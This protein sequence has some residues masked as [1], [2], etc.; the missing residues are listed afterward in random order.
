MSPAAR[1]LA[2]GAVA[3]VGGSVATV[4][5]AG[6][7][8]SAHS[9]APARCTNPQTLHV[10][11]S[12]V[13]A[14]AV[15]TIGSSWPGND[16]AAR[17]RCARVSVSAM[18]DAQAEAALAGG[19]DRTTTL[20]IPDSS[21]WAQRLDADLRS[22]GSA[23]PGV[24]IGASVASSPMVYVVPSGA[25][26]AG[27][28]QV[29]PSTLS[30]ASFAIPDPTSSAEGVLAL[31]FLGLS[32]R[33]V[34]QQVGAMVRLADQTIAGPDAGFAGLLRG[35]PFLASEQDVILHNRA[36]G[37]AYASAVYPAQQLPAL[38]FP[39]VQL[40]RP[41]ERAQLAA[42]S[43]AFADVLSSRT[44]QGILAGLG[45][46]DAAGRPLARDGI[47]HPVA[48]LRPPTSGDTANLL[49]LWS[50]ATEASHTLVVID[51]SG[52]MAENAG[53]GQSKIQLAAAAATAAEAY[54]PNSSSFGLWAFSSDQSN[55]LPW[56]KLA[57]VRQ[58]GTEDQRQRLA[59]AGTKLPRLVGGDTALYDTALAAFQEIRNTYQP[60][61]VNSVVLL[62]D[63]KN[64]YP[65][66][67]TLP[68]LLT[69]LRSLV[70][71]ARPVPVITI[72]IGNQ[73]DLATLRQISAMTGGKAYAV[74][75]PTQVR[76]VFLDA[77]LQRECRPSC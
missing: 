45:L 13:I 38:D 59:A 64:V 24:R 40:T 12:P 14:A 26:P 60:G 25:K 77:M 55:G 34:A 23:S 70:D 73:A 1:W 72:G 57:P 18:D 16:A 62:T 17:T 22:Q 37:S 9:E 48:V 10:L 56:R 3:V 47:T 51:V 63:G 11:A 32:A 66:G 2:A 21:I 46:R 4:L 30:G 7:G 52:S 39:A 19:T 6:N 76:G 27:A 35:K 54:F 42:D 20:W 74:T 61:A 50:A 8:A 67:L 65:P 15:S 33:P 28:A 49:R 36:A 5:L 58:L 68:Q 29:D 71:P 41:G 31:Q 75:D 53:N 43:V 69:K 44:S